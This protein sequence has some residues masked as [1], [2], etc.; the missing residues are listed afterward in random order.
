MCIMRCIKVTTL[1]TPLPGYAE[2]LRVI[3]GV[4]DLLPHNILL[5]ASEHPLRGGGRMCFL[6][7]LAF[8]E[9]IPAI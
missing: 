6:P 2:P 5:P 8:L 9:T 1:Q 3:K 7:S 4:G